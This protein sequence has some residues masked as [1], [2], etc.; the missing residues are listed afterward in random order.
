MSKSWEDF[1]IFCR[2]QYNKME[3]KVE[4]KDELEITFQLAGFY[5]IAM[6]SP[7][8]GGYDI[9]VRLRDPYNQCSPESMQ[10]WIKIFKRS[11]DVT[12]D[13]FE[14]DPLIRP[15]ASNLRTILNLI[16]RKEI[17]K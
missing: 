17:T 7:V 10:T 11:M 16:Q 14:D 5:Q 4:R 13:F 3:V 8:L 12:K 2:S 9:V 1:E 15:T 6:P